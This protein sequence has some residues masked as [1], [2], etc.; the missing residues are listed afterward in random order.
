VHVHT[1][2]WVLAL[3]AL[4]AFSLLALTGRFLEIDAIFLFLGQHW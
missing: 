4:M 2:S 3:S 1:F